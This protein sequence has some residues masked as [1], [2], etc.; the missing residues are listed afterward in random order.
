MTK[1]TES[2]DLRGKLIETATRLLEQQ[3]PAAIQARAVARD[4]GVSTMAVYSSF[5]GMPELLQAVAD[6]GYRELT[7]A[8]EKTPATADPVA[9]I[10]RIALIYRT[11]ARKNP[12]L[13]DLMFGLSTRGAYRAIELDSP[14]N[15]D[16]RSAPYQL[17][18]GYLVKAADRL[19]E[20]GRVRADD[21]AVIAAQL[22]SFVHG[23]I[24]LEL[25][26]YLAQFDDC[27]R[28]VLIPLGLNMAVGLGDSREQATAS[29]AAAA[30]SLNLS[31]SELSVS[32]P[33]T[34]RKK[35]QSTPAA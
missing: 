2:P 32:K 17:T 20:S 10:F 23:F 11:N 1:N 19:V 13:Y 35:S 9:D 4:A 7:A 29:I 14:S 12:H 21:P 22:W 16:A 30:K 34:S 3:G 5:G 18:Y 15:R 24:S 27:V 26:G 28:Q 8:F 25:A 6:Q 31:V 33:R